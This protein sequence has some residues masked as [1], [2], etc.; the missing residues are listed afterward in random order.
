MKPDSFYFSGLPPADT[1]SAYVF[2]PIISFT[3]IGFS[4]MKRKEP[5][6]PPEK[7]ETIRRKLIA[8]LSESTLSAGELSVL[9]G[10][11]EKD[12]H[13]HLQHIQ[14]TIGTTGDFLIVQPAECKKCGFLFQKRTRLKKPSKCPV[15]RSSF[16]EEPLFAIR[17]RKK[18]E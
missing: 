5:P 18:R 4:M 3:S 10:I 2:N 8:S 6:I 13:Q 15:C 16:I 17:S 11:P 12:V 9:A 7:T 1:L 14:K